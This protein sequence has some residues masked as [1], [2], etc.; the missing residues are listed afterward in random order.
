M[1]GLNISYSEKKYCYAAK[2][3]SFN[4]YNYD[5]CQNCGRI[6]S[7][8]LPSNQIDEFV[9]EGGRQYPD[10]LDY[11]GPGINF[12]VSDRVL[13][14][15]I[16]NNIT[17]YNQVLK[18][19][20]HRNNKD[21]SDNKNIGYNLLNITGKIDLNLKAMSLKKKNFCSLCE[22]F[23]WSRQRLNI[24]KT[25]FDMDTWNECDLCRI[26]SFPGF[27]VCSEKLKSVIEEHN[28]SGVIFQNED[29]IFQ[30]Q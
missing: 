27:V 12:I 7:K 17:G 16:E 3:L 5:K 14:A 19:F 28:F 9:I 26:T 6:I 21:F 25:V 13:Q 29:C 8:L 20:V 10:F 18:V 4:G 1:F 15:F 23:D 2:N 22:Q 30:I 11:H 24:I